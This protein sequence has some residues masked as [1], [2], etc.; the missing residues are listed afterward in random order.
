MPHTP[1]FLKKKY[2]LHNAPEV[3][4]A[5]QRTEKK[6]GEKLPRDPETQIQNYLD[7]LERLTLDPNKE[8]ERKMFGS[9]SR[10]RALSLLPE[11]VMNKYVRPNKGKMAERS[12]IAVG[13][14]ESSLDQWI[15]YLSDTNEPYPTWF[16]YYAFRNILDLGDY[17]K[18]KKELTKRSPGSVRL[19]PEVDRGALGY[20]EQMI[21]AA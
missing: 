21:E 6:T 3:K 8:Q 11:L 20:V 19:F 17:D 2:D 14:A 13:D 4:K 7:R 5:A 16:R 10:S 15:A 9:E 18:D 12:E 1:D